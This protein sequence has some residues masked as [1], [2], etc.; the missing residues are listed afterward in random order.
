MNGLDVAV[1]FKFEE[2]EE[3]QIEFGKERAGEVWHVKLQ[4]VDMKTLQ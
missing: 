3:I 4:V 1:L 2:E